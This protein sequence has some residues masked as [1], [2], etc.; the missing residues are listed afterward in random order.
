MLAGSRQDFSLR[1]WL[2]CITSKRA[3]PFSIRQASLGEIYGGIWPRGNYG[4]SEPGSSEQRPGAA[5]CVCVCVDPPLL[6]CLVPGLSPVVTILQISA[7]E[8]TKGTAPAAA[9][10]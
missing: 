8:Q 4:G 6:Q 9:E 7:L 3:K 5:V 10:T 2:L 1:E